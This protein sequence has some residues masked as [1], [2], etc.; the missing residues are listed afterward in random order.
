[1]E[2]LNYLIIIIK[3]I[4]KI[5]AQDIK[6]YP[7]TKKFHETIASPPQKALQGINNVVVYVLKNRSKPI[8]KN[9]KKLIIVNSRMKKN[10]NSI[11]KYNCLYGLGSIFYFNKLK[12]LSLKDKD[13]EMIDLKKKGINFLSSICKAIFS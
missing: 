9:K 5:K 11:T 3:V 6:L 4:S 8:Y 2:W 12:N 10:K 13:V 1:M 7:E